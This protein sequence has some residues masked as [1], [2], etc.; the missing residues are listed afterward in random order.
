VSVGTG[1]PVA[2]AMPVGVALAVGETVP[3]ADAVAVATAE[4]VAAA[5][6]PGVTVGA[7]VTVGTTFPPPPP[8]PPQATRTRPIK[9]V[10]APSRR[11]G[12]GIG[13]PANRFRDFNGCPSHRMGCTA[14]QTW[15][16]ATRRGTN[17]QARPSFTPHVLA[18][19]RSPASA[20][21]LPARCIHGLEP[22]GA[23][24]YDEGTRTRA[25]RVPFVC[26]TEPNRG[27]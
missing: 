22:F 21:M 17:Q 23:P 2:T 26:H 3:V 5:E 7:C 11:C 20:A 16:S 13:L 12:V 1:E 8:P 10:S 14:A 18:T 4:A 27:V 6:A 24:T 25:V 19:G 15:Q 9:Q